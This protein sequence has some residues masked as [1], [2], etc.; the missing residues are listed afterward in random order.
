MGRV[1]KIILLFVVAATLSCCYDSFVGYDEISTAELPVQNIT[2]KELSERLQTERLSITQDF[3]VQGNVTSTDRNGNFYKTFVIQ[4]D[5][6][7]LEVLEGIYDS[8]VRH[9]VGALVAV[10]LQGLALSTYCGVM[11]V[12][13]ESVTGSYYML[14]YLS[15]ESLINKHIFNSYTYSEVEP[16]CVSVDELDGVEC[17]RLVCIYDLQHLPAEGA[18]QPYTWA[19]YQ[20][21]VD[22]SGGV[23]YCYTSSYTNFALVEMPQGVVSLC[24]ILQQDEIY[25]VSGGEQYIIEMRGVDDC[26][27][28]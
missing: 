18:T 19:G 6:Y 22:S 27:E 21:F 20:Q 15:L 17:G 12:G 2:I 5:G 25:G 14:D 28:E 10:K 9:D 24:G 8:Y 3:I 4:S 7:A 11:Q 13:L 16:L 1:V 23:V 26:V